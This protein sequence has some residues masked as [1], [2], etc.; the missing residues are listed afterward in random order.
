MGG[1]TTLMT[2]DALGVTPEMVDEDQGR[3]PFLAGGSVMNGLSG[4]K[5]IDTMYENFS[6][7]IVDNPKEG[8]TPA[9][10]CLNSGMYPHRNL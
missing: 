1:K 8:S 10:V 2:N 3:A 5:K 7:D 9:P 6:V 4:K